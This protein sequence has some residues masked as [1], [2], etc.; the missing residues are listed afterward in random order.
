MPTYQT[1]TDAIIDMRARGFVNTFSIQQHQIFC[2]ELSTPFL[3]EQLTLLE[4]HR[5]KAQ[6]TSGQCEIFGFRTH[7]NDLGLMTDTY[8]AYDPAEFEAIL[9]RCMQLA[10]RA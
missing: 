6:N 7:T 1:L 9:S 2:S 4:R 8:A 5:V 3:P 10:R